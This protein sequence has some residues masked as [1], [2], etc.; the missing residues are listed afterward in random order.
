[1]AVRMELV[2]AMPGAAA[3]PSIKALR[4]ATGLDLSDSKHRIT[5]ALAG[6]CVAVDVL[7]DRIEQAIGALTALGWTVRLLGQ[8]HAGRAQPS[9]W[10]DRYRCAAGTVLLQ[11]PHP[12]RLDLVVGVDAPLLATDQ[13]A[14]V[15]DD[16]YVLT[17]PLASLEAVP[18]G[19]RLTV[20]PPEADAL[21]FLRETY[22]NG[23]PIVFVRGAPLPSRD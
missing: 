17:E 10:L 16:D 21:A 15:I 5:R 18:E 12:E 9:R 14:I 13:L 4:Q 7:D 8:E 20:V 23:E 3:V 2:S 19:W 22:A 11:H 1:M 6:E